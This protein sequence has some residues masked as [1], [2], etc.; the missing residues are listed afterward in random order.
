V[1]ANVASLASRRAC[2]RA[3][4]DEQGPAEQAIVDA[5]SAAA[6]IPSNRQ[7][8]DFPCCARARLRAND[9]TLSSAATFRI[10]IV[11]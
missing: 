8:L 7:M 4:S 2:K 11:I 3:I 1:A 9:R 5:A 10:A 6:L